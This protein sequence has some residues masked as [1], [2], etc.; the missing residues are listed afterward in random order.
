MTTIKALNKT[1]LHKKTFL[2]VKHANFL[3]FNKTEH[4]VFKTC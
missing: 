1:N 2:Q 4:L 3:Y